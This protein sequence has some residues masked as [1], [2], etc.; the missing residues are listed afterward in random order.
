LRKLLD[1]FLSPE[2]STVTNG[3]RPATAISGS[4]GP[5]GRSSSRRQVSGGIGRP[6]Y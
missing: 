1:G 3:S 4:K 6:P 5:M 2:D